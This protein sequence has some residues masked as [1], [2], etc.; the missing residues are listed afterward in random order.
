M[1][2]CLTVSMAGELTEQNRQDFDEWDVE[3]SWGTYTNAGWILSDGQVWTGFFPIFPYSDPNAGWLRDYSDSTNSWLRSPLLSNGIGRIELRVRNRLNN[4]INVFELQYATNA[5]NWVSIGT[6]TNIF[7]GSNWNGYTNEINVLT[8]AYLRILK[9]GDTGNDQRLGL[10]DI[11]I[12]NPPGLGLS[13]LSHSPSEPTID[14]SVHVSVV[15]AVHPL[16]QNADIKLWYRFGVD[17]AFVSRAMLN[18]TGS[19][20]RTETPIPAGWAGTVEYF[21]Q[22]D[23]AVFG[24]GT[25]FLPQGAS[26]APASY[27]ST[28]PY[29]DEPDPRQFGPS[30]RLTALTISE[31]MYNPAPR[32]DGRDLEFIEIFNS[33]P[34]S[35]DI[36]GF[37]LS[38]DIDFTFPENTV[39]AARSYAVIASDPSAISDVYPVSTVH[40][41]Y[42]GNLS[43][44]GNGVRLRNAQD[45]IL[46]EVEFDDQWPWPIAAD[47]AGHSLVL[48]KPDYGEASVKAWSSSQRMGG[49]PGYSLAVQMNPLRDVRIN[50]LMAHTDLPYVDFIELYNHGTQTVDLSGC[51]LT[52]D[53]MTNRFV[54]PPGSTLQSG[55]HVVYYQTNSGSA[56]SPTNFGFL[57]NSEGG[58]IYLV[59]TNAS[60]VIDA[61]RFPA[62][63]RHV[64]S[65]RSPDGGEEIRVLDQATP[66]TGNSVLAQ[67]D[68]VINEVMYHPISGLNDDEFVELYNAGS[69]EVDV[70]DWRFIDGISFTIPTGTVIEAGE[71]LVVAKNALRLMSNYPSLSPANTIG[72]FAGNL[73]DRGERVVLARP[74]DPD[75]P[76][77]DFVVMDSVTY[78]DGNRWGRWTDGGGSSLELM[79]PRSDNRR[80]MNW[81]GSDETMKSTN[82]W[83][84]VEHRGVLDLGQNAADEI[85]ILLE[86]EGECLLDEVEVFKDDGPNLVANGTFESGTSGWV[87]Q[88]THVLSDIEGSEG[89][90]SSKS[91]HLRAVAKGDNSV[92]RIETDLT[93]ALASGDTV[94]LRTRARWLAGGPWILLRLHGNWLEAPA[95]L[96]VPS[97][98]GTPGAVNSRYEVNTG[99]AISEVMH[100]PVLP[101][102]GEPVLVTAKLHDPDGVVSAEVKYRNDTSAPSTI[103]TLTMNDGGNSG[104]EVAGDGIYSAVIPGQSDNHLVA[105]SIEAVD[106]HAQAVTSLFPEEAPDIECL[107]MF[108]Q[109]DDIGTLGTYRLWITEATRQDWI[110]AQRFSDYPQTG[111]FV[112]GNFRAVYE[113]SGRFRGSPFIR[114]DGD[115]E[116]ANS[117][118]L[119]YVPKDDRVLGSR[120]FNMDKLEGDNTYQRERLCLWMAERVQIPYFNQRHVNVY[121]NERKKGVVYG[122]SQ[123]PNNTFLTSW[124]GDDDG[125]LHKL[126]DWFEF[127]DN[128]TVTMEFSQNAQLLLYE[129]T[130]GIKKKA[131]YRWS[132]RREPTK[133]F[134]DDYSSLF[135]LADVM[136]LNHTSAEYAARVPTFVDVDE[137]MRVF[138]LRH[139]I[140]DWDSYGYNRGKNASICRTATET[141][142]MLL[143]DMDHSHL[144]G[145]PTE[146]NLFSINCPT[147]KNKFFVH[148]PFLRA[149]WRGLQDLVDGPMIAENCDPVMDAYYAV[150]TDN[151]I[152]VTSPDTELKSWILDR[153]DYLITQLAGV[154]ADFEITT[155]G[156]A[157]FSTSASSVTLAGSAPVEVETVTV[158]GAFHPL[159]FTSVTTW[160]MQVGLQPGANVIDLQGYLYGGVEHTNATDSITI[161]YTGAAQDP[162]G[163]LVI[164]EIMYNGLDSYGDFVE[165]HNL[166]GTETF[167]LGGMRLNGLDF[168][169]TGGTFIG[170]TGYVV[171]SESVP[172]YASA[173]TNAEVLVGEY[174][175]SLDNG[176]ETISLLM[177]VSSNEWTVLDQVT[178]DDV[179]PWPVLADGTGPSLQL[180]DATRDNSRVGNW[181]VDNTILY[182]PGEA[183]SLATNLP[184]FPQIWLNEVMPSNV[185]F[186]ADNE[187][188]FDP[189]IELYNSDTQSVD[190]GVGGYY[191]TDD[192]SDLTRWAFAG[193][194]TVEADSH[195]LVWADGE[196]GETTGTHW[197]ASFELNSVSG[198]VA[199]VRMQDGSPVVVDYLNYSGIPADNSYGSYPDADSSGRQIFHVPT[200]GTAN[201]GTSLVADLFINEWMA[202]NETTLMDPT[203]N[204]FDDWFEIYN[205]GTQAVNLTGFTLTDDLSDTNKFTI[206]LGFELEAKDFLV[207]WADNDSEFNGVGSDLHVD[208]GLNNGGETVGLY[209]PDDTLVDWITF[210]PQL[211][212][213]GEGRWRDGEGG[214]Y[215]MPIATPGESNVLLQV[216][217]LQAEGSDSLDLSWQTASGQTY[218]VWYATDLVTTDPWMLYTNG[219][220]STGSTMSV[221]VSLGTNSVKYFKV[222]QE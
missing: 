196:P 43:N 105:F 44:G 166:S 83:T 61:V 186:V 189:W 221:T 68:I 156:G 85:Q 70:G 91:L 14:D 1:T 155:N 46:L 23:F 160:E 75:L 201:N 118:F 101:Q 74:D 159:S 113:S 175:G 165:I 121:I 53:P 82:L 216:L 150:L 28:D 127:N 162:T 180:R 26:N 79:D 8:P 218:A 27:V 42:F 194:N 178:Y 115:P 185:S 60:S 117:S 126:D 198:S 77:Q 58:D 22:G 65:G 133:T 69:E 174:G 187:G 215:Q 193:G 220:L 120:S 107:V 47:G 142:K 170:P 38:G 49:S 67:R 122:D 39:L 15:A 55:G 86:R 205:A 88:G 167:D 144:T 222:E 200:P 24:G 138:A 171:V 35:H 45:A 54:I 30:S 163:K 124:W 103:N 168:T 13:N 108:G 97:N 137:W 12:Y 195:V 123:Q 51:V 158:N 202:D 3:S 152:S 62:Q 140:R 84:L 135:A 177:P 32:D 73:S 99:P 153:R 188:D 219:L 34:V 161:T 214:I 190:L 176:G 50:E 181:G 25:L 6:V 64:S 59:D 141:W 95:E 106:G 72:D 5:Q 136:N 132:W 151:G 36:G 18:T 199:L 125:E 172:G 210:G 31:I 149:Y 114:S 4:D 173:Y 183:N 87:I 164:N 192:Y 116:T 94:T 145:S 57:L 206:P 9:T 19:I 93:S 213:V 182:T 131:R 211:D 21:V 37:R 110:D 52:D 10:D 217:G 197:H 81:A 56:L 146:N 154:A 71:Y 191:L 78:G 33:D 134:D 29:G 17:G 90:E 48:S 111:T 98:L 130:G 7:A 41:P 184:A 148:P 143:W 89:Y 204:N 157:D 2:V 179:P 203:D 209:A 207:V 100:S 66:G 96:L 11:V 112:Y 80:A 169:F 104:D 212:D 109:D 129:S 208:F 63:V 147:M 92:N 128:S 20:Y 119:F 102:A 40:G 76:D 139:M 16:E